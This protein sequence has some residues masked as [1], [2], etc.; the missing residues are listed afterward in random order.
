MIITKFRDEVMILM[1]GYDKEFKRIN[2]KHLMTWKLIEKYSKEGY[3]KFNLGGMTNPNLKTEKYSGLNEYKLSFNARCI[4]Y[5]GDFELIT[6]QGLYTLYRNSKPL[7]Y[8]LKRD[9]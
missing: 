7:R 5:A 1:D 8:I 3:R 9:K 4:E 2:A 6:N